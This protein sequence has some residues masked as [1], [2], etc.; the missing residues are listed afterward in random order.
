MK[1]SDSSIRRAV[2]QNESATKLSS[3]LSSRRRFLIGLPV[4]YLSGCAGAIVTQPF[5]C[6]DYAEV[7]PVELLID[8]FEEL[9]LE[10]Q[11][12]GSLCWAAAIRAMLQYHGS[13]ISLQDVVVKVRGASTE[14]KYNAATLREIIS[15]LSTPWGSWY[16]NNG[17]GPAIV[18]DIRRGNPVMIGL[19]QNNS[20]TGH[21]VIAYGVDYL[22]NGYTGVYL[23]D[24]ISVWDPQVGEGFRWIP[25]CEARD[26]ISFALH[27]S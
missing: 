3:I 7:P 16:V 1:N 10:E 13:D 21:V 20:D 8:D 4:L 23:I 18:E 19:K 6:L 26:S 24:G 17:L 27:T 25:G 12:N 15:G 22:I 11:P 14:G 9:D 2:G 5:Q